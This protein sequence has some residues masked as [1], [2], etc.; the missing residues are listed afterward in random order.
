MANIVP[1]PAHPTS[2]A[3][4]R[5]L[6]AVFAVL[7]GP[8]MVGFHSRM[9]GIGLVD[10][11]GAFGLG[12]DEGAWLSTLA[13]APQII[14]APAVAWLVAAYG[15]RRV[16]VGPAMVY[17]LISA[18]IPFVRDYH[19]L[20]G[21]H[22][23]H[24]A[25]LGLF[26]PATLMII[27]QTLPSKWWMS[28]IGFY[29]FRAAFTTNSGPGL[30]DFYVQH[31][32]W[33]LLYWQDVVLAPLMALLIL[34]GTSS[35]EPKRE[36][37]RSADWGGMILF[38]SGLAMLFVAVDQGNRLDWF[39]NGIVVSTLL[40]GFALMIAFFLNEVLVAHPWASI[41]A[42]SARNVMLLL[43]VSLFYLMSA[44]S[45]TALVP[46]F[47][48]NVMQLRPEQVGSTLVVWACVP[49]TV[50]TPVTVWAMHRI[51]GRLILFAG[52]CCF[53]GAAFIG[54]GLTSDWSGE[55]FRTMLVLQ[56]AGHILTFLPV[57]AVAI[58]NGDPKRAVAVAAYI[59]VIRVL[60]TQTV[61]ALMTTFIRKSEQIQS[62]A[63]GLN[64]QRGSEI[65]ADAI[66]AIGRALVSSGQ[67]LAAG[68]ATAV[69][70]QHVQKQANT[71][72]YIDAF[73]LTF[74]CAMAGLFLLAFVTKAPKGPLSA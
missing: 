74:Y 72:A 40:G 57:I 59:Q 66:S 8:F 62:Y 50:M 67:S 26:I 55:N 68:R 61:Q 48:I 4:N 2:V 5:P 21:L 17:A 49:L 37:I 65:S 22:I 42:I 11:K 63:V 7:L 12:Y 31:L 41:S 28:A 14:L 13:T 58:A 19:V 56:G 45:N 71:L 29:A 34:R 1:M 53:A 9:F 32:G 60:G 70:A 33:Q 15:I 36:L 64:L 39:E 35:R 44:S 16:I 24:G 51:D 47:L 54:T 27:F 20:V 30:L 73:W 6:L 38:G 43:V 52:L 23:V 46:N 69:L 10:L 18:M 3:M 25:L